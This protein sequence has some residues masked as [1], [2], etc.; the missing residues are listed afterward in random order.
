MACLDVGSDILHIE[1]KSSVRDTFYHNDKDHFDI[2]DGGE[3][4]GTL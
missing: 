4:S 2:L 3:W 1:T